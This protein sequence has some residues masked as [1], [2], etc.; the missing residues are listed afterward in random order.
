MLLNIASCASPTPKGVIYENSKTIIHEHLWLIDEH[1]W[2]KNKDIYVEK[3][4][5]IYDKKTNN[6][7]S[8][9][10]TR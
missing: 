5:D 8:L 7:L 9:R 1:F 3:N 6:L 10:S 4:K 2:L